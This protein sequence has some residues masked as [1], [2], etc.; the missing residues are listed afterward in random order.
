MTR[1]R[2]TP[3][4]IGQWL[5]LL[6]ALMAA[7]LP[8]TSRAASDELVAQTFDASGSRGRKQY[9][10]TSFTVQPNGSWVART[11]FRNRRRLDSDYFESVFRLVDE[12]GEVAVAIKH[13]SRVGARFIK[14]S[15]RRV[16]VTSRGY[17]DPLA[18]PLHNHHVQYTC[19]GRDRIRDRDV[20]GVLVHIIE[21]L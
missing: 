3:C 21:R 6:C 11:T 13:G 18:L 14:G 10:S 15:S 7:S 12:Y 4:R 20:I 1:D 2:L 19:A 9:C 5:A 8:A 16:T 17:L